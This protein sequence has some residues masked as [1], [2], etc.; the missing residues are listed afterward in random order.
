MLTILLYHYRRHD[1]V[2]LIR[3]PA[4]RKAWGYDETTSPAVRVRL[5]L[6]DAKKWK[7]NDEQVIGTYS[8][9]EQ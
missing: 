8:R 5:S 6:W 3:M 4:T 1:L 2:S 9:Y 7:N